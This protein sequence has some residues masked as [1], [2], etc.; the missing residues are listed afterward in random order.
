MDFDLTNRRVWSAFVPCGHLQLKKGLVSSSRRQSVLYTIPDWKKAFRI[1]ADLTDGI[2]AALRSWRRQVTFFSLDI[3]HQ[4]GIAL[5]FIEEA[6]S[7][8]K[9]LLSDKCHAM[10]DPFLSGRKA[11]G[12]ALSHKTMSLEDICSDI[13]GTEIHQT[14]QNGIEFAL[15]VRVFPLGGEVY[16]IRSFICLLAQI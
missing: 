7:D 14:Y 6:K 8:G 13:K 9:V 16:S 3:S 12:F 1:E 5:A 11:F 10:L 15:S 2:K 4:L